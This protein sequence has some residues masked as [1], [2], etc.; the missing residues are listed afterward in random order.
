LTITTSAGQPE[1]GD[2]G[3]GSWQILQ[4]MGKEVAEVF[5]LPC[6]IYIYRTKNEPGLSKAVEVFFGI[7]LR[8]QRPPKSKI[9]K[10]KRIR[11]TIKSKS[12]TV[13]PGLDLSPHLALTRLPNL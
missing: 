3:S 12:M 10:R 6:S 7:F 2:L 9:M 5:G 13:L 1:G 4:E 11:S 8:L